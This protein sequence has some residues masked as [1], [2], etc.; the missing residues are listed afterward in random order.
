MYFSGVRQ[1]DCQGFRCDEDRKHV[2]MTPEMKKK[3][4]P[5]IAELG[6]LMDQISAEYDSEE[7][8]NIIGHP[9]KLE[10]DDCDGIRC[11]I[12]RKR[13]PLKLKPVVKQDDCDGFRC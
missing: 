13:H 3:R 4:Y 6:N 2:E 7:F 11:P 5:M 12:K 10:P 1:D 8:L 9:I